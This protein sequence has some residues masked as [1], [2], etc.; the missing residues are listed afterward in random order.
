M[1]LFRI[2]YAAV[3]M[4]TAVI[5]IGMTLLYIAAESCT[6]S[7]TEWLIMGIVNA[8]ALFTLLGFAEVMETE[9]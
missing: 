4:I 3:S 5:T 2:I 7:P 8:I 6:I 9:P 1:R